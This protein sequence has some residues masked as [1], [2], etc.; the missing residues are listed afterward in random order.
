[1]NCSALGGLLVL[2][3]G[4]AVP[5][6]VEAN[7]P[8]VVV[9]PFVGP[10]AAKA[11]LGVLKSLRRKVRL[12]K[13]RRFLDKG[14]AL[15]VNVL[16]VGGMMS[17]CSSLQVAAVVEGRVR[18]GRGRRYTVSVTVY[19]GTNAQKVGR[20]E[21]MVRSPRRLLYAGRAIGRKL[22]V[23]LRQCSAPRPVG[24]TPT[25]QQEQAP[26]PAQ[27]S[28]PKSRKRSWRDRVQG[29]LDLWVAMGFS[30]RDYKLNGTA[31]GTD[32]RT[33]R[34]YE[35]GAYPELTL[36]L[37]I[38]PLALVVK[39]FARNIGLGIGYTRHLRISTQLQDLQGATQ[40]VDTTSQ[41]FIADLLLRWPIL[42]RPTTPVILLK[43]GGGLRDFNL[44]HNIVL[45]SVNYKF[46]RFGL[47]GIIPLGTTYAALRLGAD[48]RPMLYVGEEAVSAFGS[49]S[50]AYAFAV[51]GGLSGQLPFGLTYGAVFQFLRFSNT[52]SGRPDAPLEGQPGYDALYRRDP[53]RGSD[54]YLR[55]M[56]R[57]GY[58]L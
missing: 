23:L 15:G 48:V 30:M 46:L 9:L 27:A 57:L 18:K 12:I 51:H 56:I 16:R 7:Q 43:I 42:K 4:A 55:L 6:P 28:A 37:D 25:A 33:D 58:A 47:E 24:S 29:L 50:G 8:S 41:E 49:P 3:W 22:L 39:N 10:G 20:R 11:R 36:R 21:A 17:T 34:I 45:S 44:S 26:R 1:M 32:P 2:L 52:F 31:P 35:G 13:A 53:T 38:Y 54:Q 14:D 5:S 40:D 19:N